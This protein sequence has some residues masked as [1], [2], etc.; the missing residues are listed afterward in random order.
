MIKFLCRLLSLVALVMAVAAGT[1]DSI[2]SVSSSEVVLTSVSTA[3]VELD[4]A[5]YQLVENAARTHLPPWIWEAVRMWVLP[6]PA[7]AALLLLSLLLWMIGY[8]RPNPAGRF[9]A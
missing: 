5:R 3:W 6:Q 1:M 9:A 7:F 8:K 2:E 4:E